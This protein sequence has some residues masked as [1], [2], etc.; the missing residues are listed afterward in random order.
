M[1]TV[2]EGCC[3][4]LGM[5]PGLH[6]TPRLPAP[7]GLLGTRGHGQSVLGSALLAQGEKKTTQ[8][9]RRECC[10]REEKVTRQASNTWEHTDPNVARPTHHPT[11]WLIVLGQGVFKHHLSSIPAPNRLI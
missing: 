6:P 2:W 3:L 4:P 9:V 11:E 1:P 10:C 7:G 8:G 5:A